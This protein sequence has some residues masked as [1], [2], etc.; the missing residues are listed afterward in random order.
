MAER[1]KEQTF[2]IKVK[3]ELR[4]ILTLFNPWWKTNN[5]KKALAKEFKRELFFEI[6]KYLNSRQIIS[7]FGLRNT[8]KSTL[9]F[10]LIEH[11]LTK[12]TNEDTKS[13]HIIYFSFDEKVSEIKEIFKMYNELHN[14]NL[15]EGK[16]YIFFDEIQKL[17]DWQNKIKIF[18]DLYPNI[19]FFI[20]GS[21]HL[22]LTKNV[23]E[24]LTG[25]IHFFKLE[26]LSFREWLAINDAKI[27]LNKLM[28]Y[29]TELKKYFSD[30]LK[31][32]FPEIAT[33]KEEILIRKYIDDFVISRIIAYDIKKE[34][35]DADTDLL[36]TLKNI[37]FETPG[38]MLN[39]DS[40]AK[41]LGKRKESII[42]HI[43]YLSQGLVIKIIRN[44]RGSE[45]SSSR[46]L[47]KA[48][49]YHPCFCFG[50][51][52][53]KQI[54]NLFVSLLDAKFYWREK[55]KEVDIIQNK[56]P[57]EIKYKNAIEK[58][59]L[60][61]LV[62]FMEKFKQKNGFIVSKNTSEVIDISNKKI[63]AIPAWKFALNPRIE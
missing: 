26:P 18:Y 43:N 22:S 23:S 28:L 11:L 13:E 35:K 4:D 49:P 47:K 8:G 30:Y 29:E 31:T 24:S 33:Q 7:L 36:E 62:Y 3:G 42:K 14:N 10:Q 59:D 16:Y 51:E 54:E 50:I 6:V 20:S 41:D 58:D 57:V 38:L 12:G 40:L 19:K 48:Y 63:E 32:P 15:E 55:E 21:S 9:L 25:R 45:L 34:F 44:Y 52:E 17:E 5:V 56:K 27:D 39:F 1:A 61:Q 53:S 2:P 60:K 37:I 46:K